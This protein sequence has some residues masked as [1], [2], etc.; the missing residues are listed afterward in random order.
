LQKYGPDRPLL[1]ISRAWHASGYAIYS[2]L[3]VLRYRGKL[4]M[5]VWYLSVRLGQ[6]VIPICIYHYSSSIEKFPGGG[7]I[8]TPLV[9]LVDLKPLVFLGLIHIVKNPS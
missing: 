2:K 7:G 4:L 8:H 6:G 5:I 1:R 3:P 9:F